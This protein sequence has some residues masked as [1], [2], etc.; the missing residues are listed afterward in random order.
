[1][2]GRS[3]NP[4][5][6]LIILFSCLV[7]IASSIAVVFLGSF[8][9]IESHVVSNKFIRS[10]GGPYIYPLPLVSK[11]DVGRNITVGEYAVLLR[12]TTPNKDDTNVELR[13]GVDI[14]YYFMAANSSLA[15]KLCSVTGDSIPDTPLLLTVLITLNIN[16]RSTVELP[17]FTDALF[18][19]C[20][21]HTYT[22]VEGLPGGAL[23][24][25]KEVEDAVRRGLVNGD[26]VIKATYVVKVQWLTSIDD[27]A[28]ALNV[29]PEVLRRDVNLTAVVIPSATMEEYIKYRLVPATYV[30]LVTAVS[31]AVLVASYYALLRQRQRT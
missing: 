9:T 10:E 4:R 20:Q 6:P 24:N 12:F 21:Y 17:S 27:V 23:G 26:N 29:S 15:D 18:P 25:S 1:M 16:N 19:W 28:R 2:A 3:R 11:D 5:I 14:E 13:L 30:F 7:V 8:Y 31:I 22:S